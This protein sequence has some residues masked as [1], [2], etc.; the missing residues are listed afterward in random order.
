MRKL[1]QEEEIYTNWEPEPIWKDVVLAI[2][3]AGAIF[4][5][6]AVLIHYRFFL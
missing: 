3:V 4:S 2:V 6:I 5:S 1:I